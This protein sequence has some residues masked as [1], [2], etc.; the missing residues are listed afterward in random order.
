MVI[1]FWSTKYKWLK[2][3]R[4]NTFLL[5][6]GLFFMHTFG[7]N[8]SLYI[9]IVDLEM[10]F[11]R[12]TY[13]LETDQQNLELRNVKHNRIFLK[14][15]YTTLEFCFEIIV[16]TFFFQRSRTTMTRKCSFFIRWSVNCGCKGHCIVSSMCM[17][18]LD[19]VNLETGFAN[20]IWR[21]HCEFV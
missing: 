16:H 21:I 6:L 8:H 9:F 14:N 12:F 1:H 4:K 11:R 10:L 13:Y 2:T 15:K 18:T 3:L 5:S 20:R 17:R 19:H 7:K